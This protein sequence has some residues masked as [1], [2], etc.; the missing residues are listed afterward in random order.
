MTSQPQSLRLLSAAEVFELLDPLSCID[1]VERAFRLLGEGRARAP[2]VCGLHVES[3]TFHVKAAVLDDDGGGGWFV[4][5]VNA[6]F[7]GNPRQ[8]GLPTIQGALLLMDAA[9]GEPRA[10]MDSGALTALRTAAATAVA[11]RWLARADSATVTLAGCGVQGRAHLRFLAAAMPKLRLVRLYDPDAAALRG[12]LDAAAV[13]G[14]VAEAFDDLAAACLASDVCITC[15]PSQRPILDAGEVS[16]GALVAGVG[17]DNESKHELAPALLAR[18]TVI[19]DVT[20]QCERMGDLHHAIAAGA[21]RREDVRAE[22]GEVI[23]GRK[24]GR[25]ADDD[26]IVFD[27]TGMALQD[28]AAAVV[29]YERAVAAGRGMAVELGG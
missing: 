29:V 1:A 26:V 23:A 13:L 10:L 21:M 15:T 9:S 6:N 12:A 24:P 17:A 27:S 18:A 7:P 25:T 28:V 3:G 2:A 11:V 14:I 5:K 22:L 4:A 16:P 20:A 19:A 8:R